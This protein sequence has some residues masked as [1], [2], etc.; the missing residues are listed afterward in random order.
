M[1]TNA[2]EVKSESS[3]NKGK[4]LETAQGDGDELSAVLCNSVLYIV[5]IFFITFF[6]NDLPSYQFTGIMNKLTVYLI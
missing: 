1:F 5:I 6:S 4:F 2:A 3:A